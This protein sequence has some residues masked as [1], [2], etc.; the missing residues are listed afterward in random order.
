MLCV[1]GIGLNCAL[2]KFQLIV[3]TRHPVGTMHRR[4]ALVGTDGQTA[5]LRG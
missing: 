5:G 3:G 4:L 1:T 2:L